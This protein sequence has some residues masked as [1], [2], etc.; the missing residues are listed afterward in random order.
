MSRSLI[1]IGA[2][3]VA[4]IGLGQSLHDGSV[5]HIGSPARLAEWVGLQGVAILLYFLAVARVLRPPRPRAFW[6]VI[7]VAAGM[8]AIPLAS[9]MFLS[10]DMFRYVWDGR[11][12]LHGINPYVYLPADPALAPLRDTIIYPYVNRKKYARTIYPPM[13]ELIFRAVA[14]IGQTPV[15]MRAATVA[16]E[17]LAIA[18]LAVVL[19]RIGAPPERVLIYAWNP[20][21]AWEFAGNGHVDA[22]AIGFLGL[23]LLLVTL[24]RRAATGVALA[25]AT[26]VKFLPAVVAAAF[27]RRGDWRPPAAALVTAAAL[28]ALYADAGRDLT[29]YLPG[30]A[31]EEGLE[32]GSGFWLLAGLSRLG[33]QLP[34]WTQGMYIAA[35]LALLGV[36]GWLA[37]E[38]GR[39]VDPVRAARGAGRLI[40]V[41]LLGISAH[42]PW[43]F[44]WAC[45]PAVVAPQRAAIYIGS[46]ALLFY[47]NPFHERFWWPALVYLPT[48]VLLLIDARQ[49]LRVGDIAARDD[50]S[51]PA[52]LPAQSGD[53]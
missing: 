15:V 39:A 1:L 43:Y 25:A 47:L 28:Y 12:Q 36:L 5:L 4:L 41:T 26:L 49:S 23:A 18:S 44:P 30:Y 13:A 32:S 48:L 20:L 37:T 6:F 34:P 27:W 40:V 50:V 51:R 31:H 7:A 11:V 3:L 21:A 29:G 22:F 10:S 14:W 8:R 35:L 42:Y 2:A 45:V 19:S 46:A 9:P 53:R 17:A 38:R 24:R 16:F 33:G 52:E